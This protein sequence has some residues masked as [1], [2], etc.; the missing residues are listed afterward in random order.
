MA[1]IQRLA[2]PHIYLVIDSLFCICLPIL[3]HIF[4]TGEVWYI[5]DEAAED[6][7]NIDEQESFDINQVCY[8][9]RPEDFTDAFYMSLKR[10]KI[11][12]DDASIEL[13]NGETIARRRLFARQAHSE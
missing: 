3:F 8:T 4:K 7:F 6:Q 1:L 2:T 9:G 5:F 10:I 11:I 13:E 12:H